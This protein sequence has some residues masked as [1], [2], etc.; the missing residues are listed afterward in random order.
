M[1]VSSELFEDV[2]DQDYPDLRGS[3]FQPVTLSAQEAGLT[4]R[5]WVYILGDADGAL[6][7]RVPR[8]VDGMG[9]GDIHNVLRLPGEGGQ[10]G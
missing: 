1:I 7:R 8:P 2:V 5:A 10:G 6:P 4:A 3:D 9:L